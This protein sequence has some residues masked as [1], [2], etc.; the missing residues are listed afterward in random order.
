MK[1]LTQTMVTKQKWQGYAWRAVLTALLGMAL[2]FACGAGGTESSSSKESRQPE[3]AVYTWELGTF[4][5]LDAETEWRIIQDRYDS[6]LRAETERQDALENIGIFGLKPA[7]SVTVNDIRIINYY[8]TYNACV[9][10]KIE[11]GQSAYLPGIPPRP[12]QIDGIVFPW[13]HPSYPA[14]IAWNNGKFYNIVELYE[15]GQL[16][17]GNLESIANYPKSHGGEK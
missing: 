3:V 4:E 8:G 16:T 6:H 14:P 13:L 1:K 11:T 7:Y 15:S 2:F 5:G 12:Y 17:R 9:V 10:V